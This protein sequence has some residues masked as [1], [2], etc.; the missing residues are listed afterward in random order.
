MKFIQN[1]KKAYWKESWKKYIDNIFARVAIVFSIKKNG[2]K[3]KTISCAHDA[4]YFAKLVAYA[5]GE[6]VI[7]VHPTPN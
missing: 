6:M 4:Q 2:P 3:L 5:L 7:D 1:N